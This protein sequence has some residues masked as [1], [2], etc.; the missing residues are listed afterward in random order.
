M[1]EEY[2]KEGTSNLTPTR[3]RYRGRV[4]DALHAVVLDVD[5]DMQSLLAALKGCNA[6]RQAG[7]PNLTPIQHKLNVRA[8][9]LLA[10]D[11]DDES[12]GAP[13]FHHNLS[14]ASDTELPMAP[15][16]LA[17]LPPSNVPPV[18][19]LP[20]A[21]AARVQ[22]PAVAPTLASSTT[23]TIAAGTVRSASVATESSSKAVRHE[24]S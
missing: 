15:M 1:I 9:H 13:D 3:N 7:V 16:T 20:S 14:D 19:A 22:A 5:A 24:G 12:T 11:S 21:P 10:M 2:R 6:A 17:P 8:Q 18:S 23:S 4:R